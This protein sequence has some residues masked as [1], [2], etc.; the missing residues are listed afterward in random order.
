M[1]LDYANERFVLLYT[2]DTATWKL[3]D[4]EARAVLMFLLR[5]VDRSGVIDVLRLDYSGQDIQR[6]ALQSHGE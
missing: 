5:K 3:L 2:R 1:P 4:W 6:G